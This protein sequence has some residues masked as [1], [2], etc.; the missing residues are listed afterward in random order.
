MYPWNV[1]GNTIHF[2]RGNVDYFSEI[3][4][5][6]YKPRTGRVTAQIKSRIKQSTIIHISYKNIYTT[7]L[8]KWPYTL[9]SRLYFANEWRESWGKVMKWE[10]H[11]LAVVED[12]AAYSKK[13]K[14]EFF[15]PN[16]TSQDELKERLEMTLKW[17]NDNIR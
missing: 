8:Q 14:Y 15:L 11:R 13:T 10:D 4:Y 1:K 2:S 5:T 16:V 7:A 12:K 9:T 3:K 6:S 17:I